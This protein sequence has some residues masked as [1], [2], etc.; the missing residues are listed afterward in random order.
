MLRHSITLVISSFLLFINLLHAQSTLQTASGFPLKQINSPVFGKDIVINKDS[1]QDQRQ[2]AICSAFNGWLFA[3]YGYFIEA[4]KISALTLLKSIDNGVTWSILT[5]EMYP[6]ENNELRNINLVSIGDSIS[7]IK[8]ILSTVAK[9][10]TAPNEPGQAMVM[11]YD[12]E[13]GVWDKTLFSKPQC[14]DIAIAA[15]LMYPA[16]N[17]NP[18]SIGILYSRHTSNQGDS[19]IF[20]SSSDGGN[21]VNNRKVLDI[22]VG[23]RFSN[24]ALTYGR[25]Q[26]WNSGRYFA[27]WVE[28]NNVNANTGHI[29]T[30]HSEPNI[31]S[32][33]TTPIN[34]D[35]LDPENINMC[36]NPKIACQF[37]NID[38]DSSNLTEIVL[39]EKYIIE[40]NRYDIE[41]YFNKKATNSNHFTQFSLNSSSDNKKQ[42]S[43]NFNPFDSTFMVTYYDSTTQ[44]LP[45][46][47]KNFNLPDPGSW[48]IVT[49]GYNDNTNLDAPYPKLILNIN[50]KQ[51]A[52]VWTR[53]GSGGNGIAMFDAPYS[54]YTGILEDIKT[55]DSKIIN[56]YPIPCSYEIKIAFDI[57][58]KA[59]VT[60]QVLSIL[61]QPLGTVTNEWYS[62]G[63]HTIRYDVSNFPNGTYLF[64]FNSGD[65]LSIIEKFSILR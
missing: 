19:I 46:L 51:G 7:N 23:K 48:E 62:E 35:S 34:L 38:N 3:A 58:K 45:F 28:R 32:P 50:E 14:Y 52:N 36:Q 27:A 1:S 26:S 39:F 6:A 10:I 12:D 55:S 33:F 13:A 17:S 18:F 53:E 43:I 11:R 59:N 63:K 20:L 42:P 54:T 31:D 22:T 25:T 57:K 15:D 21:T 49:P 40:N 41:G 44:K 30:A 47:R 29:Y 9:E 65:C 5:D 24:V 60:I 64:K 61:G 37:N 4:D 16:N 8:V 2:I 56:A